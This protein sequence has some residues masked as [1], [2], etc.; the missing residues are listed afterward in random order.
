ME[1]SDGI[2]PVMRSSI[3]TE[4]RQT[5]DEALLLLDFLTIYWPYNS[6]RGARELSQEA[7][8]TPDVAAT[9]LPHFRSLEDQLINAPKP[10]VS[11]LKAD[12]GLEP[13]GVSSIV[14]LLDALAAPQS[15]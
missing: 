10:K 2:P 12:Y 15:R 4:V 8:I 11:K 3:S 13:D 1:H 5:V 7:P 9:Y 6:D 14:A